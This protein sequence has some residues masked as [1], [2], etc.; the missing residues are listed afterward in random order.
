MSPILFDYGISL[1]AGV[2]IIDPNALIRTVSQGAIFRQV[3]GI[4]RITI[5]K[6]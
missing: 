2:Q 3:E 1:L 6:P 5:Q 4:K